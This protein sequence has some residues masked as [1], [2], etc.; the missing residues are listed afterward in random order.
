M[1]TEWYYSKAGTQHGPVSETELKQLIA[2]G[3][4]Q[5]A[6]IAWQE[7]MEDWTAVSEIPALSQPIAAAPLTPSAAQPT[8]QAATPYQTPASQQPQAASANIPTYLW[9]SIC[10]TL[11]CCLIGGIVAIV[12]AAKVEGLKNA[13]DINGAMEASNKAKTWCMWSFIL[14]LVFQVGYIILVVAGG[15]ST[16]SSGY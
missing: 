16:S 7:G 15:L 9:Q 1:N 4:V 6:D 14:G 13:G 11:F 2:N 10:V 8:A 3:T 12:H 5:G